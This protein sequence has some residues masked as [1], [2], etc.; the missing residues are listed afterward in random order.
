M[1][2]Q[3]GNLLASV[4]A[5]KSVPRFSALDREMIF[6]EEFYFATSDV[7]YQNSFRCAV[8]TW[9][10]HSKSRSA[11]VVL[12]NTLAAFEH[13]FLVHRTQ[14]CQ[15]RKCMHRAP[16]LDDK[17]WLS[18]AQTSGADAK[19]VGGRSVGE[20]ASLRVCRRNAYRRTRQA[21]TMMKFF[22]RRWNK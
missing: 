8:Q 4:L 19:V 17:T 1:T 5:K 21:P 22:G 7:V 10:Y 15:S 9:S 14:P 3:C 11:D 6:D 13:L 2:N 16:F 12:D 20:A 18:D